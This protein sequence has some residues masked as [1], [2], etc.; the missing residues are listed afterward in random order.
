MQNTEVVG[1]LSPPAPRLSGHDFRAMLFSLS[2]ME[3]FRNHSMSWQTTQLS[4]LWRTLGHRPVGNID[5]SGKLA[6]KR[7]LS[8]RGDVDG[9]A[10]RLKQE[11]KIVA[12]S[13]DVQNAIAKAAEMATAYVATIPTL[14]PIPPLQPIERINTLEFNDEHV[15][16]QAQLDDIERQRAVIARTVAET[17][18]R[19]KQ[20]QQK[21]L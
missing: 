19:D 1:I 5:T 16:L 8:P 2:P 12:V 7:K 13:L 6:G 4:I 18:A 20:A 9:A 17:I 14:A 10:K 3:P 11:S 21:Q 15:R